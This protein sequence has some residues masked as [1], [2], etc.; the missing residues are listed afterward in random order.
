MNLFLTGYRGSGKSTVAPLVAQQLDWQFIDSDDVIEESTKLSISQIFAEQGETAFRALETEAI[1]KIVETG[2]QVVSLG[3]GAPIFE[4]N[5]ELMAESGKV[6]F[7]SAPAELLWKRIAG[8]DG[9][10]S[11]RPDLTD[12]GG[13]AEVKSVLATRQP[14]YEACADCMIKVGDLS[15][16]EIS[17][18]I[19][20]WFRSS[21][22]KE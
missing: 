15:P 17:D 20:K 19:V 12:Q 8:D 22:E 5:R 21:I 6:V 4:A 11:R 2:N 18:R 3:G 9:T 16:Q 1:S 14:V 13:M 10:E 7:L